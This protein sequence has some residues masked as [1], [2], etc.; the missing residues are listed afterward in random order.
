MFSQIKTSKENK[1]IVSQITRKWNLGAE[2][3]IARIAFA[4]SIAK[5]GL[6]DLNDLQDSGGKEYSKNVLFGEHADI[7]LGMICLKYN[8]YKTDKRIGKYAK[9]HLDNGLK[10]LNIES[11]EKAN[12]DGFYFLI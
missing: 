6:L 2:N 10:L 9:L 3:V 4:H 12:I 1:E 7:Y 5:S 8:L 11:E